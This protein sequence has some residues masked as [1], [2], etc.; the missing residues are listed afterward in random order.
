[1]DMEVLY[2]KYFV[3]GADDGNVGGHVKSGAKSCWLDIV[4]ETHALKT[5]DGNGTWRAREIFMFESVRKIIDEKSLWMLD[6][7]TRVDKICADDIKVVKV[8]CLEG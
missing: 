3:M 6:A 5:K 2:S 4:R 1:M 8:P 7:K